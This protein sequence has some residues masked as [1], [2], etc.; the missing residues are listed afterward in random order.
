MPVC[1]GCERIYDNEFAFCPYCGK[2]KTEPG[3]INFNNETSDE[4]WETC[5]IVFVYEKGKT[6][7]IPEWISSV[8]GWYFA[9]LAIG[10]KGRYIAG[11]SQK[12]GNREWTADAVHNICPLQSTRPKLDD[13]IKK[14]VDDEW[15]P[16][17]K[18]K[19]WYSEKFRR[20]I[21]Q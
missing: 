16:T 13:L 10:V 18:G 21:L 14:L 19:E 5:E 12:V 17:G 1:Q 9:A 4:T 11:L 2:A 15:Q 6:G 8:K 3:I 20:K 7:K